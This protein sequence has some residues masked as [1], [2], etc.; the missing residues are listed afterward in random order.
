MIVCVLLSLLVLRVGFEIL[1]LFTL[2]K[3]G[4]SVGN[5]SIIKSAFSADSNLLGQK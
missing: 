1:V 4:F 2:L 5:A 3:K